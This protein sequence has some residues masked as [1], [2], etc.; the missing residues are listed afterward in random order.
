M[1]ALMK[2][3]VLLLDLN[4]TVIDDWEASHAGVRAI[5]AHH[6]KRCPTLNEYIRAVAITGDYHAFYVDNGVNVGRDELYEIYLPAY[7]A[8]QSDVELIPGVHETLKDLKRAGIEIH[9]VTAARKDFAEHL[10]EVADIAKYC[11]SFHCH[12]HDKHAQICAI[13]NGMEV[14]LKECAMVGDLPSDVR[15][16]NWAGITSIGFMNRHVPRDV[17]SDVKMD[18]TAYKFSDLLQFLL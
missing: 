13:I 8:H 10:I 12:V 1:K 6:K 4:G 2:H 11:E 14:T 7:H 3:R 9:I 15:A 16:A 5:F 17:F 18:F